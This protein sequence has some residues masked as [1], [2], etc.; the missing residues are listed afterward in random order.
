MGLTRRLFSFALVLA[1]SSIPAVAQQQPKSQSQTDEEHR[2][3]TIKSKVAK[4]GV[5]KKVEV[6]LVSNQMLIGTVD[7]IGDDQ[8]SLIETPRRAA[9]P[10][11][12]QQ[13]KSIKKPSGDWGS[14]A[15]LIG[16]VAGVMGLAALGLRGG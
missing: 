12:Y 9:V 1:L 10:L 14:F 6:K 11:S 13:V 15:V 2:I 7:V 3:E 5:G 16:I 4:I 8:F